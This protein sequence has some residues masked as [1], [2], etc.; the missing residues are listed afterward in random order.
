MQAAFS[1]LDEVTRQARVVP[2]FREGQSQGFKLFSIR[3]HSLFAKLGLVN[4]D[5]LKRI[6]GLSLQ[7]PETA[8]EAFASL[9][10]AQH[11]NLDLERGGVPIHKTYK[12]R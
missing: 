2:S 8:L 4:G 6:N 12:V 1:N 7:T 11:F 10:E 5:V 3:P 9:H